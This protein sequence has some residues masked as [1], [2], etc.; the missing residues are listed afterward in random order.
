M[1]YQKVGSIYKL[2]ILVWLIFI[3]NRLFRNSTKLFIGVDHLG[4]MQILIFI[5]K[6]HSLIIYLIQDGFISELEQNIKQ[7]YVTDP[8]NFFN[9]SKKV[10]LQIFSYLRIIHLAPNGLSLYGISGTDYIFT[11]GRESYEVF[12]KRDIPP[13]KLFITG[14]PKY[15]QL[16][17]QNM[18][19]TVKKKNCIL[20]ASILKSTLD[21]LHGESNK[22][23][24][25]SDITIIKILNN[26]AYNNPSYDVIIKPHPRES[27]RDYKVLLNSIFVS[28]KIFLIITAEPQINNLL[29]KTKIL[30][31]EFSTSI[32]EAMLFQIP[33][34]VIAKELNI[35]PWVKDLVYVND[36]NDL[37]NIVE[38]LLR[39]PDFYQRS[40]DRQ[41]Q[42]KEYLIA[43]FDKSASKKIVNII[44]T[45]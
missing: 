25:Q 38:N 34:C 16:I 12:L 9:K 15:D 45:Y 8:F 31:S 26:I 14:M 39:N 11:I 3:S 27:V 6:I 32:F 13:K 21:N 10:F 35:Y 40:L 29:P 22:K 2:K 20:Y 28:S 43:N 7:Q 18:N 36:L 37:S 4:W 24:D 42:K 17:S 30:I 44:E 41:N 33:V 23:F 1:K 5:A 19:L